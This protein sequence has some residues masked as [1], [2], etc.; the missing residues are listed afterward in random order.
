MINPMNKHIFFFM[1]TSLGSGFWLWG[2][3]LSL[4]ECLDRALAQNLEL[5]VQ[6]TELR[7]AQENLQ[8]ARTLLKPQISATAD[9]K[10]FFNVPT[11]LIPA[12]FF[13]GSSEE[14]A[15]GQLGVPVNFGAKVQA[16]QIIYNGQ[17][18]MA[19]KVTKMAE[20][21]KTL[22]MAKTKEDLVY[23]VSATFYNLQSLGEQRKLLQARI[24]N[25]Q[26]LIARTE[27]LLQNGLTKKLDL[28]RLMVTRNNL[29]TR[30]AE[31]Q[32]AE[33]KLKALLRFFCNVD[34]AEAFEIDPKLEVSMEQ[35]LLLIDTST[36]LKR[37]DFQLLRTQQELIGLQ[38]KS[39][40][41]QFQ[42]T[43]SAFGQFGYDGFNAEFR[44]LETYNGKLFRNSLIGLS[45][46]VPVFDGG[47][48]RS[49]LR[50]KDLELLKN[51]QQQAMV[52]QNIQMETRNALRAQ[53]SA[54]QNFELQQKNRVL[55]TENYT[56]VSLN[57]QQGLLSA[58]D[59][60][61]A[62]NELKEAETNFLTTFIKLKIALLDYQKAAGN[63]HP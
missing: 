48:K 19:L 46:Q 25:L 53:Q 26:V 29:Q 40:L 61:N 3:G 38:K 56:Q 55:A 7:I 17:V 13:G 12:S 41:K 6:Q 21:L 20:G 18:L 1:L 57:Y 49:Q 54:W 30:V 31:L 62:E 16:N 27:V 45:L 11:Q 5:K 52:R 42:P 32:E 33:D 35:S 15:T 59:V 34:Q 4:Q 60:I 8:E 51:N 39:I 43:I 63:L 14:Y 58:S 47:Q 24:Q 23:N 44:G 9:Y 2:Q 36:Y 37:S 50:S 28:D 10:Y 22:Q